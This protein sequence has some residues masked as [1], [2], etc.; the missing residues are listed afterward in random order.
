[1]ILVC[2]AGEDSALAQLSPGKLSRPHAH[3]EGLTRCSSCH[4]LGSREVQDKCLECHQEIAAMRRSGQ[5]LHAG[6]DYRTCVDCH[7]EHHGEDYELIFWPDGREGFD[8]AGTGFA[9]ERSHAGL[10]CR[11]CHTVK[12]LT[13]P[14]GLTAQ[15]K[16]LH[17]TY[18]GLAARCTACHEDVHQG[19]FRQ[20]CTACHDAGKWKPAPL[21]DHAA[22][23]FPLTGKHQQV[24]CARCHATETPAEAP[25]PVVRFVPLAHKGCTDCHQDPH[26]GTLGADCTRCHTTAGWKQITGTGFDHDSTRYPLRGRHVQVRCEQCHLPDRG[27]P[28]FAACRDCHADQHRAAERERPGL[29]A[30]EDC[31][32]VDGFRPSTFSMARH[33]QTA[34]PLQG[35]HRATPCVACHQPAAVPVAGR[36]VAKLVLAHGRCTDCHRDPHPASMTETS[37]SPDHGCAACHNQE[38]WRV[39]DFDHRRTGFVLDGGHARAAC[40]ACHRGE[41]PADFGGLETACAS[42]HEDIH[43][44]QFAHRRTADGKHTACQQCHVTRDWFAEKF[45]HDTDSR[46]VLRGGHERTPCVKCHLSRVEGN[47]RRLQYRPV[48][49]RCQEC[50]TG[51]VPTA[52]EKS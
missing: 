13:E 18:L 5:G 27:K 48:P 9:L 39:P 16:D 32:T 1:M 21:F 38:S 41:N 7:V 2:A 11:Q 36:Q 28:R 8:H 10:D 12:Y 6:D 17:R 46:F 31:H 34:F 52:K 4:K 26:T 24:A 23:A 43:E 15:G 47:Q 42:C 33:Q 40:S 49:T 45:D 50:H 20:D 25:Q 30:C 37:P 3:L 29:A 19:Q 14:A 35:A 22:S 51:Q 44:G